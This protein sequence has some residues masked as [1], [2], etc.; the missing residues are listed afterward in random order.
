MSTEFDKLL[1]KAQ[2]LNKV[3]G[4]VCM[5]CHFP[6]NKENLIKLKC[7]HY[8]HSDCLNLNSNLIKFNTIKCPYCKQISKIE[9]KEPEPVD[10]IFCFE[11]LKSG[12][13]KGM[14]CGRQNCKYHKKTINN[15]DLPLACDVIIKSGPRKNMACGRI[16]CK[17]HKKNKINS[18]INLVI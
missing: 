18:S 6:D 12:P 14:V 7:K 9:I 17:Y 2:K 5:I 15:K 11:I 13:N 10:P 4:E 1:A 8:Y 16:N 3:K